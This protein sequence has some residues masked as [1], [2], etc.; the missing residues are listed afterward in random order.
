MKRK[1]SVLFATTSL[2]CLATASWGTPTYMDRLPLS[3]PYRCLNCH[4]VQDPPA[5]NAGLNSFG[6]AFKA[7]GF[8]WDRTLAEMGSDGDNC[9]NGFE[10]GDTDGD[11]TPDAGVTAERSNP[12]TLDCTLQISATAWSTLKDLFR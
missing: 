3:T 11:G 10:S 5:S 8:K 4:L 7:N 9:S 2:F 6:A 1:L 12:G